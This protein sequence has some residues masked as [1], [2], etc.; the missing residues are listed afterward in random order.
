MTM[1][2][3]EACLQVK[4]GPPLSTPGQLHLGNHRPPGQ[5]RPL[6][7]C[8]MN[9]VLSMQGLL[10]S[11]AL[12]PQAAVKLAD[13]V[14]YTM[15]ALDK[16][17]ETCKADLQSFVTVHEARSSCSQC[18]CLHTAQVTVVPLHGGHGCALITGKKHPSET[19]AF[20]CCFMLFALLQGLLTRTGCDRNKYAL[21]LLP[22][23]ST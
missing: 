22:I 2:L 3:S 9:Q 20:V 17:F 21:A 15:Q 8:L 19:S 16:N 23:Q 12:Y 5:R 4:M 13:Q 7:L 18:H 10:K 11:A 14:S 6:Y 1:L